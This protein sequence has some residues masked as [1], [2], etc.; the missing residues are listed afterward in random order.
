MENECIFCKI[1]KGEVKSERVGESEHFFAIRDIHPVRDGHTLVIPK[2][3]YLNLTDLPD[4]LGE[5]LLQFLKSVAKDLMNSG[6]GEGFNII[7][8]NFDSAG[9]IIKH[10]HIHIIPRKKNDGLRM[11][12]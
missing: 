11:V 1:S 2:E 4:S 8:N 7:M 10:A 3:H 6:Y 12:A 9:Q 5:E